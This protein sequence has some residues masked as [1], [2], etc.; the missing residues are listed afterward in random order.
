MNLNGLN[1]SLESVINLPAD[2]VSFYSGPI[3]ILAISS[4]FL[5]TFG[6]I[7]L[8]HIPSNESPFL[9]NLSE[10]SNSGFK[11]IESH[12]YTLSSFKKNIFSYNDKIKEELFIILTKE[13]IKIIRCFTHSMWLI[14]QIHEFDM[15]YYLKLE[16]SNFKIVK[17][18]D[19]LNLERMIRKAYRLPTID[20]V[21][22][23]KRSAIYESWYYYL[24]RLPLLNNYDVREY[25]IGDLQFLVVEYLSGRNC[26]ILFKGAR[27]YY[28]DEI[29]IKE[30]YSTIFD[31][32]W[33]NSEINCDNTKNGLV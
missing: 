2:F 6:E 27:A 4:L 22:G 32:T 1:T 29:D 14:S 17:L 26:V 19:Y 16:S 12:I 18:P 30:K 10:A 25:D 9:E 13:D 28:S 15:N 21:L 23:W 3:I 8:L 11:P 33:E 7:F 20:R 24:S 5:A 31:K